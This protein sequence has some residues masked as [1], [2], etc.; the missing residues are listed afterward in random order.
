VSEVVAGGLEVEAQDGELARAFAALGVLDGHGDAGAA[1]FAL[2]VG[3][4]L[5]LATISS[6]PGRATGRRRCG[7]GQ[8]EGEER[9][10]HGGFLS[11][12]GLGGPSPVRVFGRRRG[13][14]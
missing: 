7:G 3:D 9:V 10:F 4:V 13:G 8:E 12:S 1:A 2:V 14:R 6:T 11:L 5:A